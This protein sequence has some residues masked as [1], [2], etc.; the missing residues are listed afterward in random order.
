MSPTVVLISQL[1]EGAAI[2]KAVVDRLDGLDVFTYDRPGTGSAPPRPA[3]NPP[4][5]HSVFTAELA[6]LLEQHDVTGPIVLVG[7]SFGALIARAFTAAHP[8]RVAGLVIVDGSLPQFHVVPSNLPKLDGDGPDATEIDVVAGQVEI[9]TAPTPRLPALVLTRTHGRWDGDNPPPHPAV[10][11]LWA[12]SQQILARDL[13]CPLLVADNAGHQLQRD[14][15][16]LVAYA[17]R[18]VHTAARQGLSVRL[19]PEQV[20][21]AGGHIG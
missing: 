19:D 8:H 5:P 4:I 18:A 16:Q 1:G 9:L 20:K 14:A 15:P 3:P 7:H 21:A 17:I 2:W 11:D 10:E 12:V 6:D 13:G